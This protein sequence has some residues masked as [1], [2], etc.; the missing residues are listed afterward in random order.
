VTFVLIPPL[1]LVFLVLGTI[2][3]GIA[4][5][6]EGGAMG[7]MGALLMALARGRLSVKLL[8]NW[9]AHCRWPVRPRLPV[10]QQCR[11]CERMNDV[12]SDLSPVFYERGNS[13][14][15]FAHSATGHFHW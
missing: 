4:T 13:R 6:S 7:A 14:A 5:P 11:R 1:A 15:H 8:A 10:R 3:L 2:F 9:S 12:P